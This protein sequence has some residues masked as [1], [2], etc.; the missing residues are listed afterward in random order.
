[1]VL[2]DPDGREI[3]RFAAVFNMSARKEVLLGNSP[4]LMIADAGCYIT[5]FANIGYEL[6]KGQYGGYNHGSSR[7]DTVIGINSLKGIFVEGSGLLNGTS[8][9]TLFGA[10]RWDSLRRSEEIGT[11]EL[12]AKLDELDKSEQKYM[13]AGVF[14]LSSATKNISNHMVGIGALPGE[15]GVFDP[16]NII[17][18]STGDRNRLADENKRLAYNMDNLKEIRII[19][20]D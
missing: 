5:T 13:I 19:L 18:T 8:M 6:R 7:K 3:V 11:E 15:D 9:N 10:G 4:D 1:V 14:D 17:P 16:S 2:T 12:L 20:V